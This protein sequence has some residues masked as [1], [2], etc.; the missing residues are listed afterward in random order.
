M[1]RIKDDRYAKASHQG[2]TAHVAHEPTIAEE[3][4]SFAQKHSP[5]ARAASLI[6]NVLHV[7][8]CHEL[9]FFDIQWLIGRSASDQKIGLSC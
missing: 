3:C 5:V 7:T 1:G 9:T 2:Q 8:W 4:T 6:D